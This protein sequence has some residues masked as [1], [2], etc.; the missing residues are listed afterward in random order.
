MG[1]TKICKSGP[2]WVD[3]LDTNKFTIWTTISKSDGSIRSIDS[4]T[5]SKIFRIVCKQA[6]H[7]PQDAL[8]I[9]RIVDY[10]FTVAFNPM[11]HHLLEAS[12]EATNIGILDLTILDPILRSDPINTSNDP[13]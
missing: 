4:T 8:W 6:L 7:S 1:T 2:Q 10:A 12:Q 5:A 9:G 11:F 13:T 3:H